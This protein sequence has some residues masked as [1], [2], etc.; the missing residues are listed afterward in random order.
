[1][2]NASI[3]SPESYPAL[4]ESMGKVRFAQRLSSR[5]LGIEERSQNTSRKQSGLESNVF[6]RALYQRAAE[7]LRSKAVSGMHT[8]PLGIAWYSPFPLLLPEQV[9][10]DPHRG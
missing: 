9:G 8:I 3:S 6:D 2:M 7:D 10:R 4:I 5:F 1:M